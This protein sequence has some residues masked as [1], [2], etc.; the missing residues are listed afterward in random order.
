MWGRVPQPFSQ[1]AVSERLRTLPAELFY[2]VLMEILPQMHQRWQ[3]RQR[4]LSKAMAWAL[5]RFPEVWVL[6]GSPLDALLRKVDLLRE[7]EGPGS[8]GRIAGPVSAA[9]RLPRPV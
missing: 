9:S 2:R 8:A 4:P 1:Q 5:E 7:G 6:G 3:E